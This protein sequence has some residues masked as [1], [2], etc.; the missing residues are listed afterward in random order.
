MITDR[1]ALAILE[2][3]QKEDGSVVVPKALQPF[4]GIDQIK[5][6]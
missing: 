5:A 1:A 3:N 6:H 2:N 4:M